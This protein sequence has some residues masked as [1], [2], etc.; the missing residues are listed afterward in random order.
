MKLKQYTTLDIWL[1]YFEIS[2][3]DFFEEPKE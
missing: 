3:G 2:L 1:T